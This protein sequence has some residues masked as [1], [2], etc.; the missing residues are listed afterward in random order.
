[1]LNFEVIFPNI[2]LDLTHL[3]VTI[4]IV[5]KRFPCM[6]CVHTVS[7]AVNVG[8]LAT[9]YTEEPKS[10]YFYIGINSFNQK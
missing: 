1:M 8:G 10:L 7:Q 9:V 6:F 2:K 3:P 4:D 5:F